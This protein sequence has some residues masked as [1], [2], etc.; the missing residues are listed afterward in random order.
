[1]LPKFPPNIPHHFRGVVAILRAREHGNPC[2]FSVQRIE[3][4]RRVGAAKA[5]ALERRGLGGE[6][7][8]RS[9]R[10]NIHASFASIEIAVEFTCSHQ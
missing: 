3:M 10:N 4:E 1:V 8:V 9:N 2:A 6:F 7:E 5:K